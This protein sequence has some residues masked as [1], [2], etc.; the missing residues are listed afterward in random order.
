MDGTPRISRAR[1]LLTL[2]GSSIIVSGCLMGEDVTDDNPLTV[3]SDLRLS[4]SVGDG[5]ITGATVVIAA[6]DGTLLAEMESSG[7]A[8]YDATFKTR[9]KHYPLSVS[10]VGGTDLVT[11][12]A[13]DFTLN[14]I[15]LEP[16]TRAVANINPYS[17]LALEIAREM[18]GGI[19]K[20]SVSSAESIA[21][22]SLNFGLSSLLET[23]PMS[24]EIDSFSIAEIVKA[25][26]ALGETIR[27]TR[28]WLNVAGF[29]VDGDDVMQSLGSDL[30]DGIIDGRGGSR[31]DARTAAIASLAAAQVGLEAMANELHVYGADATAAMADSIRQ[32]SSEPAQV[33]LD[34]ITGTAPMLEQARTALLAAAA[35]TDDTRIE[36][37]VQSAN[38]LQPGL[39]PMLVRNLLPDDYRQAL[40]AALAVIAGGGS[41]VVNTMNEQV[42]SLSNGDV[43]VDDTV[44]DVNT[45][46]TISGTPAAV[47]AVDEAYAFTPAADDADGDVLSFTSTGLPDWLDL[48]PLTGAVTGSPGSGDVNTYSGI[49]ITVSDGIDNASLGPFSI[50]VEA[51]STGSVTLSWLPPTLNEDGTPLNDLAGYRIYWGQAGNYGNS[52]TIDNPGVTSFVVDNL[53]PGTYEFVSTAFNSAGVESD[54]SNAAIRTVP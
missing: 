9:G 3:E 36:G 20:T 16:S 43:P 53:S 24:T 38:A 42:R 14:G 12:D 2:L 47:V 48:D 17:T 8:R 11:G 29:A 1:G 41:T 33:S 28:D 10:A 39:E 22:T 5:P 15:V 49:T 4:G 21:T 26:E 31:S 13:P 19:D 44:P 27:R 52:A 37:L 6:S 34:Q 45:A 51:I 54:Y 18:Q 35:A 50:T 40:D 30:V 46:P 7:D 25:S 32:V 23:G